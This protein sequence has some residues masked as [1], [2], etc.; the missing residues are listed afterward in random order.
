MKRKKRQSKWL[1]GIMLFLG[2]LVCCGDIFALTIS[3]EESPP[4]LLVEDVKSAMQEPGDT[5]ESFVAPYLALD[6]QGSRRS[7]YYTLWFVAKETSELESRQRLVDI[8]CRGLED[9]NRHSRTDSAGWLFTLNAADFSPEAKA[10]V[11]E[12]CARGDLERNIVLLGAK[13]NV[14]GIDSIIQELA[15]KPIVGQ[16]F[17][18]R[19]E[20]ASLL[21]L[22]RAGDQNALDR[23]I[24]KS[25][26][27]EDVQVW[28]DLFED[29]LY[30]QKLEGIV[31]LNEWLN[32]DRRLGATRAGEKGTLVCRYIAFYL[33]E[34]LEGFP[35]KGSVFRGV[36]EEDIPACREWMSAQT[37]WVIKG[38]DGGVVEGTLD[39]L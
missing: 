31:I 13:L 15:K 39:V 9:S 4:R 28:R 10:M 37:R 19:D 20:W 3:G 5:L 29:L 24:E 7:S 36:A 23:V 34:S 6:Y 8:L 30:I 32:S 33:S 16:Y 22:A 21:V 35:V 14:E 26:A 38:E 12:A 11:A 25:K 17:Y 18:R 2:V 27:V 1:L